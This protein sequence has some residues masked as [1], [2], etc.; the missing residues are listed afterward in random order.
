MS[1]LR[2]AHVAL[3]RPAFKGDAPAAARRS[4]EGLHA[5][6]DRLNVDLVAPAGGA[7]RHPTRDEPLPPGT[8]TDEAEARAVAA[9]LADDPPDLLLLQHVTFATGDLIAPLVAAASRLAV[10]ALPE[11]PTRTGPLPFNALCGLQM[12][13]S[14]LDAPQVGHG[15]APVKWLHGEVDEPRFV[16][17][18]ETT[19]AAL[20]AVRALEHATVLRI[21]GTAP[22]F[23]ALEERPAA[24]RGVTVVDEELAT[25]FDRVAAVPDDE[26]HE[27]GGRGREGH[28]VDVDEATLVRGGRIE[29]AL[30]AMAVE[31]GA[32]ALAVRCWP[33]LPDRCDAM[34]CAAMGT[35]AGHGRPAACEGDL[36]GALSMLALQ[37][38]ADGPSILMD[39]SELDEAEDALLLWHCGNAPAAWA[40]P[41]GPKPRLTTHFNRDGVGPVRD[42]TLAPGPAS[43]LRLLD[44]GR[45]ALI[46]SGTL[47]GTEME[48]FDG[49]RGWWSSPSWAGTPLPAGRFLAELL[50]QRVPHHLALAGGLHEAALAE[51]CRW[52]GVTVR[53]VAAR[54]FPDALDGGPVS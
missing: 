14:L 36:M 16:R 52:L 38:V 11:G 53:G 3:V 20:R 13:L 23:Y 37:A 41:D 28:D 54:P 33:E 5:L 6:A 18:F 49:V 30:E 2:I 7:A 34:A 1:R 19:V 31:A 29:A 10:W 21:G 35:L 51:A 26:A 17:A 40:A 22:G 47:R 32:D 46:A 43:A 45:S 50:D 4:R 8:V 12:T 25:L 24:L 48:G 9:S 27:R 44:G 42:E 15:D 39:L